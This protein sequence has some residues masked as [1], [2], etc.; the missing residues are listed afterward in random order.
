MGTNS[1]LICRLSFL[2]PRGKCDVKI[3]LIFN[4]IS[5]YAKPVGLTCSANLSRSLAPYAPIKPDLTM[6]TPHIT[7]TTIFKK[8][9]LKKAWHLTSP[10][11]WLVYNS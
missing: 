10:A 6:G 2:F 11:Y 9:A 5:N 7:K 3:L 8:R 1:N 4:F